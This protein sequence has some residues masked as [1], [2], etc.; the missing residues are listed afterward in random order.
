[1]ARSYP[2]A[3]MIFQSSAI[4]RVSVEPRNPA[5]VRELEAGLRLIERADPFV[6]VDSLETGELILGAAGEVSG[7]K[8]GATRSDIQANWWGV[9]SMA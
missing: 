4:V 7:E 6:E 9:N 8:G 2:F 3:P 5:Q 1:M